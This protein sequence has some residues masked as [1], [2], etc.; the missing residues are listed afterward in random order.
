MGG[1]GSCG[2]EGEREK[3]GARAPSESTLA[4]YPLWTGAHCFHRVATGGRSA[5]FEREH[6]C[7]VPRP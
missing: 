7:T 4:T 3:E 5:P 1:C 6:L 2:G